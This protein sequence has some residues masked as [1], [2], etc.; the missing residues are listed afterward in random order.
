VDNVF[1][2]MDSN[3]LKKGPGCLT[4]VGDKRLGKGSAV[5]YIRS[6]KVMVYVYR[7]V[8][9]HRDFWNNWK[10]VIVECYQICGG[11][12]EWRCSQP[13]FMRSW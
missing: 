10:V 2:K 8:V 4:G 6:V 5:G 13:G 1:R 9:T 11:I 7:T 12:G 3:P